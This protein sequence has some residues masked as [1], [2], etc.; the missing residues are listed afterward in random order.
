VAELGRLLEDPA[1]A[2]QASELSARVQSED[3]VAAACGALEASLANDA[4]EVEAR[5]RFAWLNSSDS[6]HR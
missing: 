5:A 2:S 6:A 3:G 1:F 4:L